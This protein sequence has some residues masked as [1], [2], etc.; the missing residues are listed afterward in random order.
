LIEEPSTQLHLREGDALPDS[1]A[2]VA[3]IFS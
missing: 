2:G 1:Q 3:A